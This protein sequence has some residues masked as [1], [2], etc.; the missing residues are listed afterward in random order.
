MDIK[1]PKQASK[2]IY[3]NK[4]LEIVYYGELVVTKVKFAT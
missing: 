1:S 4:Q 2:V 3:V